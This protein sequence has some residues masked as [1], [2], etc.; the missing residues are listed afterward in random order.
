[1]DSGVCFVNTYP[2]ESELSV[3]ERVIQPSNNWGLVISGDLLAISFVYLL[4]VHSQIKKSIFIIHA[5]KSAKFQVIQVWRVCTQG[6]DL[7][8]ADWL[9]YD[10]LTRFVCVDLA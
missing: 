5:P 1:M 3:L 4:N 7:V 10:W 6:N 2:L 8:I 9:H